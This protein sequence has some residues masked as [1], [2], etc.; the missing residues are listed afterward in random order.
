MYVCT[1]RMCSGTTCV[2]VLYV[3]RYYMCSGT[4]RTVCVKVLHVCAHIRTYVY[5]N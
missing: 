2:Q 5:R 1:V 3:F 4:I